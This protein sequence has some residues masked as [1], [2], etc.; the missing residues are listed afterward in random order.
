MTLFSM[1]RQ[2][3]QDARLRNQRNALHLAAERLANARGNLHY[4]Q[5]MIAFYEVELE[6][7]DHEEDFW[8]YA[9]LKQKLK[10]AYEELVFHTDKVRERTA[11]LG[12]LREKSE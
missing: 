7:V 3:R 8:R 2:H 5:Q 6:G 11:Q 12:A 9:E 10:D 4:V 1:F